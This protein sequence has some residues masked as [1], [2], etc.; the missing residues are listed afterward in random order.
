MD[1]NLI[2]FERALHLCA[3]H[4]SWLRKLLYAYSLR[5]LAPSAISTRTWNW[6]AIQS[7]TTA[8]IFLG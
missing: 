7:D 6:K 2:F 3:V 1:G 5:I 4:V 8:L